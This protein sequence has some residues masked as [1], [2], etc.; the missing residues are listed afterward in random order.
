MPTSGVECCGHAT[1]IIA[2]EELAALKEV[3]EEAPDANK[4]IGSFESAEG[5]KE[6]LIDPSSSEGK[7]VC[8]GTTLSSE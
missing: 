5:F 2:A 1:T 7:M 3:T 6:V 8:I 4:S